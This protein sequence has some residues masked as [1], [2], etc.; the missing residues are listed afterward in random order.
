MLQKT[1][2]W[3]NEERKRNRIPFICGKN[4]CTTR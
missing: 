3:P 1:D 4:Q 2:L